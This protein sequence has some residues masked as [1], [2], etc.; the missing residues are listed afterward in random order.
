[1]TASHASWRSPVVSLGRPAP[2]AHAPAA[3][4]RPRTARAPG[5][6]TWAALMRRVFDLDAL[7]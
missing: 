7:A 4:A 3:D 6:W 1:V 2:D 5:A